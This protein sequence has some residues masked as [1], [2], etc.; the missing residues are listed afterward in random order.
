VLWSRHLAPDA[1]GDL[2]WQEA[3]VP[4]D[5]YRGQGVNLILITAPGPTNDNAADRAGWGLPWLMRGTPDT[6]FD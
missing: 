3:L 2:D 5:Q 4:L 6:R 1:P